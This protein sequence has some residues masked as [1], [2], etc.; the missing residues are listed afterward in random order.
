MTTR[1]YNKLLLLGFLSSAL[2][3]LTGCPTTTNQEKSLEQIRSQLSVISTEMRE[4]FGK[5][6]EENIALYKSLNNDIKILQKNQADLG[7]VS[8][9]LR[10]ALTAINAKL[11]EYNIRI[12]Q[13]NERL[14]TVETSFT[15]RIALLAEQVSGLGRD[16][17]INRGGTPTQQPDVQPDA[18][19]TEAPP[20]LTPSQPPETGANPETEQLYQKAYMAYVNGN[21]DVAIAGFE[22]YLE[23]Y[24]ESQRSDLAQY[25][26]AE[27]LFSQGEFDSALQAYDK[28]ITQYPNSERIA[29]AYFSKA[30]AYLKLDRQIEAISHL[31]YILNQYPNSA[32]ARRAEERLR[33]LE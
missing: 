25:W 9:D 2:L 1:G 24:P 20:P 29:A 30:D 7:A 15:E 4:A 5:T 17:G 23:L 8:D 32:V 26:I 28:L 27:S 10:V 18:T 19:P 6:E 14:K 12:A 13:L 16:S 31:R 21:F 22:R 3:L 11:D 33:T